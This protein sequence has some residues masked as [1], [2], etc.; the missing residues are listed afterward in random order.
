MAETR[1][2]EL[3]PREVVLL[4]VQNF[5]NENLYGTRQKPFRL[6]G[7]ADNDYANATRPEVTAWICVLDG[8]ED[9]TGEPDWA[10]MRKLSGLGEKYEVELSLDPALFEQ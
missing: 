9:I 10:W 1:N 6:A 4:E 5:F 7:F 3:T 2:S 8:V